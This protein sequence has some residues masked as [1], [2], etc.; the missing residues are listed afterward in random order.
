[1]ARINHA[2][3]A[4]AIGMELRPTEVLI[5]GNPRA[6]APLIQA[7]PTVGIDRSRCWFGRLKGDNGGNPR[8]TVASEF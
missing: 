4:A 7:V 3:A 2:A 5:F 6:G 1:M 8:G